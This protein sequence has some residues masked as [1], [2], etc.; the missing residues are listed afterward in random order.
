MSPSMSEYVFH[1]FKLGFSIAL[2]IN[3]TNQLVCISGTNKDNKTILKTK[4]ETNN[5]SLTRSDNTN[6]KDLD[7][8]YILHL[9]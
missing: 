7:T 8:W 2:V 3:G 4:P 9:L 5:L 6:P 1:G